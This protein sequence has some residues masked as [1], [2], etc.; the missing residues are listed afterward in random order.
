[1]NQGEAAQ[2]L[3]G[4][5]F[6][7]PEAGRSDEALALF[8]ELI[9]R[10]SEASDADVRESVSKAILSKGIT[11]SQLGRYEEALLTFD[12]LFDRLGDEIEP[13]APFH[14]ASAIFNRAVTLKDMNRLEDAARELRRGRAPVS[15]FIAAGATRNRGGGSA[16]Q[17]PSA[18]WL[19]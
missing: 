4:K 11:L 1:M 15:R 14:L 9:A 12:T 10:F 3:G 16:R 6:M 8:E 2:G 18:P 17:G 5:A 13:W 7:L 19:W